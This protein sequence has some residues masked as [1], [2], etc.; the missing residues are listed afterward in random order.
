MEMT[1]FVFTAIFIAEAILK[2]FAFGW[3][4]FGTSWNKFDF[5]VV[6]S[7]ILDISL[8]FYQDAEGG[9]NQ[10]GQ[11]R[12]QSALSVAPQLARVLRVLRV[13]RVLRIAGHYKGL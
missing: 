6:I 7:S 8:T 4:Y 3:S 9:A 2:L 10:G 13:S 11:E 5:F 12:Q 1:N